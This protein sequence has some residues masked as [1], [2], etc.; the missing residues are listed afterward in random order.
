MLIELKI[1]NFGIIE[2][3]RFRPGPGLNMITGETGS[4]K[5]L[6]LQALDTVLGAR[7]G[8]GLV[9]NGSTRA[10]I[11]AF[12]DVSRHATVRTYL[13]QNKLPVGDELSL[14]REIGL[15]GR[16]KC[17]LNNTSITVTRI[18][19]LAPML[20]EVHGQ[21]EHQ[22]LLDPD[23]HLDS[24]D[25]FAGTQPLRKQ[26][27]DYHGR[28]RALKERLRSVSLEADE[29]ERR[30][31]Y[32]KF[33]LEEIE[34]FEPR[35]QEYEQLQNEKALIQNSGHMHADLAVSYGVLREE[36]GA[37][38]DR[39]RS[40]EGLLA[41]H[42]EI[43]PRLAEYWSDFQEAYYALEGMADFLRDEK[44]GLQFSPE[45]LEDVDERLNTYRRLHKK[46]GGSTTAVLGTRD[47]L[48]GELASI[49]MS[50]E[51]L[52]LLRSE[53]AVIY[54][55]MLGQA[56]ELS[57]KRRSRVPDLEDRI[58]SELSTLGM[59]GA[60]FQVSVRRE[61]NPEAEANAGTSAAEA[62]DTV[63]GKYLINDRGLDR[64][65]F[66]LGANTGEIQHPLRKVASGGELSRIMLALK[67]IIVEQQPVPTLLFD[68]VDSGVGGEVALSI[69][70]RLKNLAR[71]SQVIVVTH[72][73][74]LASLADHH[75]SIKKRVE[76]GRTVT[77][78]EKLHHD[79]RLKELA[80][81]MG[82]SASPIGLEH[83]REL[84]KR[85][86]G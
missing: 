64:V 36:D 30:L 76:Q 58:G 31:D 65:E 13:E 80:R 59:M 79:N 47:R 56:E 8:A 22:R 50:D 18:R 14:R 21:H 34:D 66:F 11:E 73:H 15:D 17:F 45:R 33:S 85:A 2:Q 35:E 71:E 55:E 68:E 20:M 26:V 86:A 1:E 3:L 48:L 9:R 69:G 28:Y 24:L 72:L 82:G 38:L 5:S 53:L 60:R 49:E 32:I 7:A 83:A 39:L 16:S 27:A 78:I 63:E 75:F 52:E 74:Q 6:L 23:S 70:G 40:L 51:E 29:R 19:G 84:L 54:R 77:R 61:L 25:S 62:T 37:V 81:M 44:D 10:I 57:R 67:T 41:R 46:Y 42:I 12:F 43:S 4:G